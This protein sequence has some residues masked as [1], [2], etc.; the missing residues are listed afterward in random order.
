M[1]SEG[2]PLG[3]E[4]MDIR[5]IRDVLWPEFLQQFIEDNAEYP[6]ER[7]LGAKAEWHGLHRKVGKLKSP[8]WDEESW[9][10]RES[11]RRMF[12]E[13]VGHAFLAIASLDYD[14][15]NC[16][17]E[18]AE[19]HTYGYG[20]SIGRMLQKPSLEE[21]AHRI[22]DNLDRATSHWASRGKTAP[23]EK[24]P[25]TKLRDMLVQAPKLKGMMLG[26][27]SVVP[28]ED[29]K[30]LAGWG[31][32]HSRVPSRPAPADETEAYTEQRRMRTA[33]AAQTEGRTPPPDREAA[34]WRV[35][36]CGPGCAY[37]HRYSGEC[38][39]GE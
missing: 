16:S 11:V 30:P 3:E 24:W 13:I 18:C 1:A 22:N 9:D 28:V 27:G 10:G 32:G 21:E 33:R 15:R 19:N 2:N 29:T 4:R 36:H 37:G 39:N 12:Q 20:C 5:Y 25:S 35:R 6:A 31:G 17:L 14:G 38:Q 8:V 34:A 7:P 26:P 23:A